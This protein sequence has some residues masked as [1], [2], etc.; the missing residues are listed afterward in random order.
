LTGQGNRGKR[1]ST[2]DQDIVV[3]TYAPAKSLG[4]ARR[5]AAMML[6][7]ATLIALVP[8]TLVFVAVLEGDWMTGFFRAIAD[9]MFQK[10]VWAILAATSPLA[11]ALLVGYG[12]MQR[13]IR[14]RAE[15]REAALATPPAPNASA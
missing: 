2:M 1:L 6:G 7:V 10:P 13:A 14:R 9:F 12:Y 8:C 11:G 15:D 5:R 4:H 3:K